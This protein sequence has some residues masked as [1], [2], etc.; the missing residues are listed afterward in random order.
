M[1]SIFRDSQGVIMIDCL[2]QGHTMNGAYH[3]GEL[4]RLGQEITRKRRGKMT[5]GVLLLQA[6]S[7]THNSQVTMTAATECGFEI[8]PHP[9]IFP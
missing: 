4:R 5:R 8:L 1:A 3:V 2:K 9:P 7:P 6:D